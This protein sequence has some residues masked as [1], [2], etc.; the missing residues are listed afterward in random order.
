M[1]LNT[2]KT[3]LLKGKLLAKNSFFSLLAMVFP[4][5]AALVCIPFTLEKMGEQSFG[6][7]ILLWSTISY[8][9]LLDFGIKRAAIK[10]FAQNIGREKE[11]ENKSILVASV[12]FV[13]TIGLVV[14][15]ILF[16]GASF[17][18]DNILRISSDLENIAYRCFRMIVIF[19][20][21]FL[22]NPVLS[23]FL[24]A[25]QKFALLSFLNGANGVLNYLIPLVFLLIPL[26]LLNIIFALL[27][28][29]AIILLILV[30]S[31]ARTF[32]GSILS[33]K[34]LN[35]FQ[36]LKKLIKFGG[37]IS[38]SNFLS[39]FFDY[40]DRFFLASLVAVSAVTIYAT[41]LE[42]VMK[43]GMIA[44]SVS[45]VIFAAISNSSEHNLSLSKKIIDISLD[46]ITLF[47]F[48]ILITL[49]FFANESLTFWVGP[50][51]ATQGSTVIQIIGIGILFKSNT[52]ISIAYLH[53]L[54]KP[55]ITALVHICEFILYIIFLILLTEKFGLIGV[56]IIHSLRLII[57]NLSFAYFAGRYS[58]NRQWIFLKN[59]TFLL[60]LSLSAVPALIISDLI[61]KTVL[62]VIILVIFLYYGIKKVKNLK[63]F[64][65]DNS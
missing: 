25:Y 24:Q 63:L 44:A 9:T 13:F 4:M 50:E 48:P 7:L 10:F 62:F 15:G 6:L 17:F 46:T 33:F 42:I 32:N 22:L 5:V 39:P 38:I 3:H 8:I 65:S 31:C 23:S 53:S 56:A 16:F 30:F 60:L 20:P 40:A 45:G 36:D 11:H 51:I 37:W 27:V 49:I 35:L 61:I 19:S 52:N 1:N 29:K 28:V 18:V 21:V 34:E 41:P 12:L 14:A 58:E 64:L 26:S 55:K 43:V 47:T 57:D 54:N 2:N 59:S